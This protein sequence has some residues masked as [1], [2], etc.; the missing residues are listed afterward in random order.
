MKPQN[1]LPGAQMNVDVS[2]AE[3][4]KCEECGNI[5]WIQSFIVKRIPALMSPSGKEMLAPIEVFSCGNC[6][7]IN[8][9]MKKAVE[10]NIPENDND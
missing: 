2:N 7:A 8:P 6:G 5:L 4:L 9:M 1:P 10:E 3:T